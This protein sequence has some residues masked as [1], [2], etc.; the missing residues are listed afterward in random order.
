VTETAPAP[1]G[2]ETA[3]D[4]RLKVAI[5][6]RILGMLG[7]VRDST[8]HVSARIPGTNE[9]WIRCRGGDELGLEF[10]GLHN[11]RRVNFDGEGPGL[12]TEH[13][14]PNETAIHGEIYKARPEV[15]AVVH[16]HPPYAL[17]CGI[18]GLEYRPVFGAFDPSALNIALKGVPIYPRAITITN[19]ELGADLIKVMGDRDVVLMKG[20]GITV[21]AG[22]VEAATTQAIRF[23]QLSQIMWQ[24]ALS[25]RQAPDLS[26][27]DM[28]VFNRP[29]GGNAEGGRRGGW[30]SLSGVETWGWKHYV[31]L[32]QVNNIGLPDDTWAV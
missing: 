21:T 18:T 6:C 25:G 32:L 7:L 28:A 29:R 17:L 8:G 3:Q 23:D 26:P 2:I 13:A 14:A 24:L 11:V 4:L 31:K 16:A 12:G 20:H 27:E 5:S 19:P 9:M 1:A 22:T 30:A 10:T 15:Q